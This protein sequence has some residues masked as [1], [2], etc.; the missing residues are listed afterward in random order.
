[1]DLT[2]LS[3]LLGEDL[4][5]EAYADLWVALPDLT[6]APL[7]GEARRL[8][9][10][11][12]C[13]VHAVVADEGWSTTAIA[14]GADRVHI[15]GDPLPFL[16]GAKPEFVLF[17]VRENSR[18]AQLAQRLRAGLITDARSLSIDEATRALL[19]SHPVYGGEYFLDLAVTSLA[20]IATLDP[21]RLPEPYMDSSRTG[22]VVA[23]DPSTLIPQ[24]NP[25][26][27]RDLGL[28]DYTPQAWRP[29]TRARVIV[30]AGRGVRDV[31][32][33]ALVQ[34]LAHKLGAELAG[35]QSACDS[36]WVDEAHLVSVT[37]QEV[38]PDLYLA[39][40]ILGDT[41][42]NAAIVGARQVIA[43]HPRSDAPIFRAADLAVV[44][45]PKELLPRLLAQLG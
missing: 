1:M 4:T 29:L 28:V 6:A 15:V 11:L 5:T 38:A 16:A 9:D 45:E 10:G 26:P 39:V 33:F 18:A 35:D 30:S 27:V 31:E 44:A 43:I 41:Y 20:K 7:L 36:G 2:D 37:G 13:Y 8:A 3:A 23:A 40:G 21:R 34:Q 32:G 22:E 42:H 19:G 14:F 25:S 24:G 12:G 17:P